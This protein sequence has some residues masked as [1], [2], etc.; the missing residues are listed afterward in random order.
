MLGG[1]SG[2]VRAKVRETEL[3]M[4]FWYARSAGGFVAGLCLDGLT[5]EL[6]QTETF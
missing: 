1:K 4:A 2:M 6:C 5:V 3:R